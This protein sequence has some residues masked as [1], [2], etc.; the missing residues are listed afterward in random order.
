MNMQKNGDK[1]TKMD[2]IA[3][4]SNSHHLVYFEVCFES[5]AVF[6]SGHFSYVRYKADLMS[7]VLVLNVYS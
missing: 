4:I 5:A 1:M 2:R 6:L 3:K 7:S